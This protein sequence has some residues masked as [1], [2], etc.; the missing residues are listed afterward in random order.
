MI[1]GTEEE[2]RE[3][4]RKMSAASRSRAHPDTAVAGNA[5]VPDEGSDY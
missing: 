3:A 1:V 4:I 5:I 2:R